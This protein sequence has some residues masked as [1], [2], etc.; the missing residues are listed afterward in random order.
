MQ[1]KNIK[2]IDYRILAELLKN[3]NQTDR[4]LAKALGVS[5]PTVTRRITSLEKEHLW[6]YSIVPDFAKLGYDIV[7]FTFVRYNTAE[8]AKLGGPEKVGAVA[9]EV[10]SK[11]SC[12]IFASSGTGLGMTRVSVSIHKDYADYVKYKETV[13]KKLG[14]AIAQMETFF[15]S[16]SSDKVIKKLG[17]KQLADD[18]PKSKP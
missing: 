18:L 9:H 7:A 12:V 2:D 8:Y 10:V 6:E 16:L 17:F 11:N 13:E 5:Q 15:V 4:G 14:A 1:M 3:S